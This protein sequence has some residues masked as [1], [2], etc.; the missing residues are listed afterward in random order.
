MLHFRKENLVTWDSIYEAPVE[1]IEK[2]MKEATGR[3]PRYDEIN[4]IL[5]EGFWAFSDKHY[6][7]LKLRKVI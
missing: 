2:E 3:K 7:K 4:D 5:L 6:K 1:L